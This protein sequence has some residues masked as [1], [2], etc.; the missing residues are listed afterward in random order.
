MTAPF[1]RA[2]LVANPIA[3]RGRGSSEARALASELE[4]RGLTVQLFETRGP[5]EATELASWAATGAG[6]RNA[7]PPADAE[8]R[9]ACAAAAELAPDVLLSIGGDGTLR[10]LL[11]GSADRPLPTGMLPMGTANVLALDFRLPRKAAELAELV[12]AGTVRQLDLAEVHGCCADDVTGGGPVERRTSFLAVGLGLDAEIVRRVHAARSGSI[13]KWSYLPHAARAVWAHRPLD[14]E[15]EVDGAPLLG[16][17]GERPARI[18]ALLLANV[19][20][21]GGIVKLD[22]TTRSDDGQWELYYWE[23]ARIPH[24]AGSFLRGLVGR[25]PGGWCRVQ[26]A[27]EVHVRSKGAPDAP[28]F[29]HV[30]GDPGGYLPLDLKVTERRQPILAPPIR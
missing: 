17:G 27:R 9:A 6:A 22:Q 21:F 14:L 10:E 11:D 13:T 19:V 12:Q 4:A 5:G 26:R 8:L 28:V 1:E 7:E 30:D 25:F 16:P 3:G 24:L 18:G 15:V 20:N 2:L 29:Y 23:R